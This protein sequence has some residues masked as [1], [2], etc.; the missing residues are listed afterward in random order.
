MATASHTDIDVTLDNEQPL[1]T[2]GLNIQEIIE[3]IHGN[4]VEILNIRTISHA[5][6]TG[7]ETLIRYAGAQQGCISL[8]VTDDHTKIPTACRAAR[9]YVKDVTGRTHS[10]ITGGCDK[11][12]EKHRVVALVRHDVT[13]EP[14]EHIKTNLH[15]IKEKINQLLEQNQESKFYIGIASGPDATFAMKRRCQGNEYKILHGINRMIALFRSDRQDY[16]RNKEKNLIE[17]YRASKYSE[18]CLNQVRGGGGGSTTQHW[19]FV[20]L[21]LQMRS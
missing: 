13:Y 16:C 19:S 17:H 3:R 10:V 9:K 20:Y 15:D 1:V 12:K 7:K 21:G 8:Y 4:E 11:L 5:R 14:R 6:T 18:K 2:Q